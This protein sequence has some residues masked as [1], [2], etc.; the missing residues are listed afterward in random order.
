MEKMTIT[1]GL[2]E[3]KLIEK[4]MEK[5]KTMIVSNLT[6]FKQVK[7]PFEKEGGSQT[8]IRQEMQ[9]VSDLQKRLENIRSAIAKANLFESVTVGAQTKSIYSWLIWKR[10]ILENDE[11]FKQSI[12]NQIKSQIDRQSVNPQVWKTEAGGVELCELILNA[13]Y[14][15]QLKALENLGDIK[16]KLDGQLSLKNATVVIEF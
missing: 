4:K 8:T 1:E 12:V 9:S 11:K 5:K 3:I 10:E 14:G 2:A 15:E 13:D 6:R 7:D 16:E